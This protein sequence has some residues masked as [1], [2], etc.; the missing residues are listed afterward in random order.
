[1][2]APVGDAYE[3]EESAFPASPPFDYNDCL[4]PP[5]TSQR[6]FEAQGKAA[7]PGPFDLSEYM[8][9][10]VAVT[11]IFP[12]SSGSIDSQ[13]ETWSAARMDTCVSEITAGLTWWEN[14]APGGNLDFN[15]YSYGSRSTGYE[16]INRPQDDEGLWISQILTGLG[17]TSGDYFDQIAALNSYVQGYY[18]TDWAYTMFVVDS[19]ND[20]DGEF[21]DGYS[22][23]AYLGGPFLV[24]TYDNDGYG[25]ANMDYVA[26]HETGHTFWATDEY[27]GVTE[28]SGYLNVQ[29]YEEANC[30]MHEALNWNLCSASRGQIGWRDSDSD[31]IPD[32]ADT[33]PDTAL[34]PYSPDPTDETVLAYDGTVHDVP[35]SNLN[36]KAWSSG[37]DVTINTLTAVQYRI[38]GGSWHSASSTDGA[39]D[40]GSESF[41]FTTPP[42]SDGTHLVET[43]AQNSVGN[44]ETS[45]SSDTI[46]IILTSTITISTPG[47]VSTHPATVHYVQAGVPKTATTYGTWSDDVDSNSTVSIDNAVTVSSTERYGTNAATSWLATETATFTVPYYHQ[48]N[49]AISVAAAGSGHTDLGITNSATLTY[50]RFGAAGTFNVFDSQS[51]SDWVDVGSTV[52]LPSTSTASTAAHRWYCPATASWTVNDASSRSA[53]YWDQFKPGISVV[54]A[55]TGHTDLDGTNCATLTYTRFG[56][57]GTSNVFDGQSFNEWVDTG[58]TASLSIASSASTSTHRW[59]VSGTS[60]W[61]VD[62]ASSRSATYWDQLKPTISVVTSG[63]GHTDLDSTNCATL[64]YTRFGAAGTS[65]V[66]DAQSLNDWVDTGSTASL[67]NPSSGSTST[68]R[69]YSPETASWA[70][71]DTSSRSATYWDQ[72]KPAISVVTAGTEHTDL[73]STNC[74]TLTYSRFGAA[75]ASSVFDAQRF[76]DWVDIGL[77]ASLSNPSSAS[78]STHRWYSSGTTSWAIS[79]ARSQ[80]ATYCE[81]FE[82]GI[83]GITGLTPVRPTTI[84]FTRNGATNSLT[85]IDTWTDWADA[86][87]TLSVTKSVEGGWIGDWSTGD[88]TDWT[89]DSPISAS[90]RYHRSYVGLYVLIGGLLAGVTMIGFGIFFLLRIRRKGYALRDLP[91]YLSDRL[92]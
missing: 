84:T 60:S 75:G 48:F 26:A 5:V 31:N 13:T 40:S 38:D 71:N 56:A 86:G 30:I 18:Q 78:T 16:P 53:T 73:D 42:L 91:G 35:L 4:I 29:D 65:S 24:M 67:S 25:I 66:F 37:Q 47:L 10:E 74:A 70:V 54:T 76:N 57:A 7:A 87:S 8:I 46:V 19:Y 1:V 80:S 11:V 28:Y 64:T 27:N 81:Q 69:W 15:I 14:R 62:D 17:Y 20:S 41:L 43:R 6:E 77:T 68:H 90:I 50:Y 89:V 88:T 12:E 34:Q 72:F 51:F 44:W 39:F 83:A 79:D 82:V 58:S 3:Q 33:F 9:G 49:P 21:T 36:P 63:N 2:N 23:Y 52:S 85:A 92:G 61:A 45:Y 32:P 22:A 55:G 59:Y